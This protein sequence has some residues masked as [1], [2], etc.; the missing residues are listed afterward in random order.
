MEWKIFKKDEPI[1]RRSGLNAEISHIMEQTN[2]NC[3]NENIR[4]NLTTKMGMIKSE[5]QRRAART[6]QMSVGKDNMCVIA[7]NK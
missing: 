3:K 1:E 2:K 5:E 6:K 4:K 7:M